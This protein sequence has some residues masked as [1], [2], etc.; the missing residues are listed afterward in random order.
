MYRCNNTA[1][2]NRLCSNEQQ[3]KK[4]MKK[5]ENEYVTWQTRRKKKDRQL[6]PKTIHQSAS[7]VFFF[8]I[9]TTRRKKKQPRDLPDRRRFLKQNKNSPAPNLFAAVA[10][11]NNTK[12]KGEATILYTYI[13]K[14]TR[15]SF[16]AHPFPP[17]YL[18]SPPASRSHERRSCE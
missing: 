2:R 17:T 9:Q 16:R 18:P 13:W 1:K 5:K 4:R 10:L 15:V 7:F 11:Q 3:K 14:E 6:K 8:V 12:K